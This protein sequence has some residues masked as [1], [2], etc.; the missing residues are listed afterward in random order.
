MNTLLQVQLSGDFGSILNIEFWDDTGYLEN[1]T[2]T[3]DEYHVFIL[4][5]IISGDDY[6]FRITGANLGA[7]YSLYFSNVTDDIYEPNNDKASA[8]VIAA[9]TA[10]SCIL[11]DDDWFEFEVLTGSEDVTIELTFSDQYGNIDV[12]LYDSLGA[13]VVGSNSETDDELINIDLNSTET[14][15]IRVF[16]N[17]FG[18]SYHIKWSGVEPTPDDTTDDT[19]GD[20]TDDTTSDTNGGGDDDNFLDGIPG[21]SPL[22][23]IMLFLGT[24]GILIQKFRK[25]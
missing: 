12:E 2:K 11:I 10:L 21:Y 14:Y 15:Y 13:L 16:G 25:K 24:L 9:S 8:H 17:N 3:T 19:T 4:S 5:E 20:T 23:T 6:Y 22:M 7:Q 18:Q 1:I